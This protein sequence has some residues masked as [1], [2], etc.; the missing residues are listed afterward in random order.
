M[1][2]NQLH[3]YRIT[4]VCALEYIHRRPFNFFVEGVN[5]NDHF[6]KIQKRNKSR[7][8]HSYVSQ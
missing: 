3:A 2:W 7:D 5:H 4:Q 8:L 1:Q 6:L